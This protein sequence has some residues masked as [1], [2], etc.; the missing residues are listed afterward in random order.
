[1]LRNII[2][3]ITGLVTTFLVMMA[4]EF[5]NS[6]I[7]PFPDGFDT[8]S[9]AQVTSFIEANSPNIFFLVVSGWIVGSFAGGFVVST[10]ANESSKRMCL[11]AGAVW[12]GLQVLNFRFLPHP[13]WAMAV[14]LLSMI[15][16]YLF[17][18]ASCS[19]IKARSES[20]RING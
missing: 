6:F 13:V 5:T 20:G 2:S 8:S 7:F 4:F 17:G 19:F 10:I 16:F 1:M 14:G 12:T 11:F 3:V 15:P 9:A 18:N